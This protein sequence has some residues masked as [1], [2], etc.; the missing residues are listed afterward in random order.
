MS[1][2]ICV[3][4]CNNEPRIPVERKPAVKQMKEESAKQS[5]A[6]SARFA[7]HILKQETPKRME[8]GSEEKI[9]IR[10]RN[11]SNRTWEKNGS[12]KL[13]HYW[14]DADGTRL[15]EAAGRMMI[16]K[17][18]VLPNG[19][20]G[21]RPKVSAPATPGE[22]FLVWDMIEEQVAWFGS[23]GAKP[24]RIPVTVY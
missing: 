12:V 24:L 15:K 14:T 3:I 18:D 1:A 21:A 9:L 11:T 2:L 7:Y 4:G 6:E 8:A 16:R 5:P 19:V 13:G 10:I 17:E 20:L 22:Y 23:K